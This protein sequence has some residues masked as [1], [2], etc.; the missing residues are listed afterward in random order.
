MKSQAESQL[1]SA[2]PIRVLVNGKAPGPSDLRHPALINYGHFTSMQVRGGKV[3]GL[4]LHLDRIARSHHDLF[5]S[6]LDVLQTQEFMRTAVEAMPDCYLR[7]VFYESTPGEPTVMTV[8]RPPV[9]ANAEPVAL[10]PVNYQRPLAHIK[11][12]GTFCKIYHAVLAERAGFDDALHTTPDGWIAETTGAN[13]GFYDGNRVY[14]PDQPSLPGIT[15]N[16]LENGLQERGIGSQRI[17][18]NV[19]RVGNF[20]SAFLTNSM[21]VAPISRIGD[22]PMGDPLPVVTLLTAVYDEIAWDDI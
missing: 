14:W 22:T 2:E 9:G 16:L 1:S 11:H 21:G 19:A 15:W 3:R 18:V 8:Q 6:S 20:A 13:I 12:N 10:M 7:T 4:A 5:G 17:P